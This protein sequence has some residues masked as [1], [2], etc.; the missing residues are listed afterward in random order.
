[1]GTY[2]IMTADQGSWGTADVRGYARIE[3]GEEEREGS[4]I[5]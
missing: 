5:L 3:K 2:F 1:M 4:E